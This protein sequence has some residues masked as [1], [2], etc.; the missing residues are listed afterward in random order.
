MVI[1][2]EWDAMIDRFGQKLIFVIVRKEKDRSIE[3]LMEQ[4][5]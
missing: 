2:V 4:R 3:S 5:D 1:L